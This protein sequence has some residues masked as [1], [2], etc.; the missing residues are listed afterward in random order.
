MATDAEV[1]ISHD[2]AD[3]T[4]A[5]L[6]K[7]LLEGTFLNV[8]V[9]VSG[10]DLTGG[11][12]WINEIRARLAK[13][14]LVISLITQYSVSNPWVLF[15]SGA[16]FMKSKCIPVCADQMTIKKLQPPL[17]QLHARAFTEDGLLKLMKDVAKTLKIRNP[18]ALPELAGILKRADEFVT[19]RSTE[20]VSK[21]E[22]LTSNL[23]RI[24][25]KKEYDRAF[26]EKVNAVAEKL[27]SKVVEKIAKA[28]DRYDVPS[29]PHFS[30][31]N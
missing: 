31:L 6:L 18:K 28:A 9:F 22:V 4:L 19:L 20:K 26:A 8:L 17:N 21:D 25:A 13:A 23:S 12:V 29:N 16:G 30:H 10:R 11:D 24:L 5:L 7:D 2:N 1:F 14:N 3:E 15:E 27:K